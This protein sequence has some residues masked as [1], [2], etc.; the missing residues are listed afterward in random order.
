[1]EQVV[2]EMCGET[3]KEDTEDGMCWLGR[4]GERGG[5]GSVGES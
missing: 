3:E 1:M 5:G 4:K 2:K